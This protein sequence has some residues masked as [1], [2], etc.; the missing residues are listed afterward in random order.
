MLDATIGVAVLASINVV[1]SEGFALNVGIRPGLDKL[2]DG[3][4][5]YG[6]TGLLDFQWRASR[7][8]APPPKKTALVHD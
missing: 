8:V 4:G 2:S 1:H 7:V 5:L 6:M 3:G